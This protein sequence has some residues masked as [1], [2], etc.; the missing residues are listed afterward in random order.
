MINKQSC[1]STYACCRHYDVQIADLVRSIST[2]VARV[3][4][5]VVY[6]RCLQSTM[7]T[8]QGYKWLCVMQL[9]NFNSLAVISLLAAIMSVSYSTIGWTTAVAD[10]P[11]TG[12]MIGCPLTCVV[13]DSAARAHANSCTHVPMS[14]PYGACKH[15]TLSVVCKLWGRQ[16][17]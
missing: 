5:P 2:R 9:P 11:M 4:P 17:G 15:C 3:C 1:T 8:L 6:H 10:R 14:M 7:A 13:A 12:T 16:C